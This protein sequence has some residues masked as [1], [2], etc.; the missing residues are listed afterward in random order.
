MFSAPP[1]ISS[2]IIRFKTARKYPKTWGYILLG[3]CLLRKVNSIKTN[4]VIRQAKIGQGLVFTQLV[5]I[6]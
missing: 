1:N 5:E 3:L 6:Q 2:G 4:L